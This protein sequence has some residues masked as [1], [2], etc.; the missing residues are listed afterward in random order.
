MT[1]TKAK[2]FFLIFPLTKTVSI[3]KLIVQANE[4]KT[5]IYY[6][7]KHENSPGMKQENKKIK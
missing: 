6:T 3:R 1:F 2:V 4:S 5:H 7:L